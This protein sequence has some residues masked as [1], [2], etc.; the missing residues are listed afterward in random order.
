M[1]ELAN[2]LVWAAVGIVGTIGTLMSFTGR[3][4]E[5]HLP[6][7][8]HNLPFLETKWVYYISF[9]VALLISLVKLHMLYMEWS[10]R[11]YIWKKERKDREDENPPSSENRKN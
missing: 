1:Q 8:Y 6:Q 3:L 9:L 4:I 5:K 2:K 10:D 7:L 11:F